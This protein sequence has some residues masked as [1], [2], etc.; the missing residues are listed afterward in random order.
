MAEMHSIDEI[1]T[2]LRAELEEA[3]R[4]LR[5]A[6]AQEKAEALRYFKDALHRFSRFVFTGRMER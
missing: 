5:S 1:E 6:T 2:H 3:E 4:T